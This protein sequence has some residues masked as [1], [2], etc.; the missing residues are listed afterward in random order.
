MI[1][2]RSSSSSCSPISTSVEQ[3]L[4]RQRR[5]ART[6]KEIAT[7][8]AT[9]ERAHAVLEAGT[10]LSQ[11]RA[12]RRGDRARSRRSSLLTLKPRLVVANTGER[13]APRSR[14]HP[15]RSRCR[16]TSRRRS[17]RA[18]PRTGPTCARCTAWARA[19]STTVAHAAYHLLGRRTFFTTGEDESRAWTFRAG[20][21]A[22]GVR[23]RHPLRSAAGVHPGRGHPVGRAARD[24]L[25][26]EGPRCGQTAS[27]GQG[28][29]SRRRRRDGD[30]FQRLARTRLMPWLVRGDDVLAAAEV[31][32]SAGAA[33]ARAR[34]V[35]RISRAR[36]CYARAARCT[37]S[38]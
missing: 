23:G 19:R 16:S 34:S 7:E 17:R 35:A 22:P 27:R 36:W 29:R 21:K 15:I 26:V 5:A 30:P 10:P 8:V 25:V 37:R 28:L 24:R 31:A 6:N 32:R 3:R 2:W 13:P 12:D 4:D 11:S 20:A 18:R 9:L 38:R 1:W 33:G 14:F